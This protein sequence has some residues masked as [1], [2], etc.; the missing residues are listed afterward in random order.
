MKFKYPRSVISLRKCTFQCTDIFQTHLGLICCCLLN[1][2]NINRFI[3]GSYRKLTGVCFRFQ[4]TLIGPDLKSTGRRIH[5][6]YRSIDI[7]MLRGIAE[8]KI[9]ILL[10]GKTY[11]IIIAKFQCIDSI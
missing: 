9:H 10:S 8:I 3:F 2:R 11:N 5:G 6:I 4:R 7:F 1:L